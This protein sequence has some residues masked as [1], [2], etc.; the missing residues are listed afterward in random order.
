MTSR[1]SHILGLCVSLSVLA[2][3]AQSNAFAEAVAAA[4]A[5]QA[6]QAVQMFQ[7]LADDHNGPAQFN[8]AVLYALGS[9]VTQN[10]ETALYWAWKARF[11][12]VHKAQSLTSYLGHGSPESLLEKVQ[13]RLQTDLLEEVNNGNK[14]A[15]LSLGRAYL[16]VAAPADNEQALVW[17][18]MAAAMQVPHASKWRDVTGRKLDRE[19]RLGAQQKAASLYQQWCDG[20]GAGYP[21]L[22]SYKS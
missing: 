10:D 14:D 2:Q 17:F 21:D 4:R 15:M 7:R 18:T 6:A 12:G 9:G 8:L 22:C 11:A 3:P 13:K 19:T 20:H 5:G 1:W 16:E